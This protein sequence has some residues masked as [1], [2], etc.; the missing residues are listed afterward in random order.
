MGS[1]HREETSVDDIIGCGLQT[2]Y[3]GSLYYVVSEGTVSHQPLAREEGSH[4]A[5]RSS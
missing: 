3:A 1:M 4:L 2:L 5:R